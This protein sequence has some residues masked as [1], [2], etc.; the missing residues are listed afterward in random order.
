MPI[1]AEV[2]A[3]ADGRALM[4]LTDAMTGKRHWTILVQRPDGQTETISS[5]VDREKVLDLLT[6]VASEIADRDE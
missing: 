6:R 2:I 5:L 3:D 4:L 1:P